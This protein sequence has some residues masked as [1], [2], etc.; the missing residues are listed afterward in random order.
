MLFASGRAEITVLF[1][2]PLRLR[3]NGKRKSPCSQ[4]IR[5]GDRTCLCSPP[6]GRKICFNSFAVAAKPQQQT[7]KIV[8]SLLPQ[9]SSPAK[10]GLADP[11]FHPGCRV[12]E[13]RDG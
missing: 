9:A 10:P 13:V 11:H 7:K 1:R 8:P 3:R 2:L 12:V 5:G 6:A 4:D